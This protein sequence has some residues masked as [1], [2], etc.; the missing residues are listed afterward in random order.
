VFF[1]LRNC[2]FVASPTSFTDLVGISSSCCG[3]WMQGTYP[4]RLSLIGR[5]LFHKSAPTHFFNY[6]RDSVQK[7]RQQEVDRKQ[8]ELLKIQVSWLFVAQEGIYSNGNKVSLYF[9]RP[10]IESKQLLRTAE[11]SK[12][13]LKI[14]RVPREV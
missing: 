4:Y 13:T 1:L 8:F 5:R 7:A 9:A 11:R 2:A 10:A 12:R 14:Q 3:F 6:L